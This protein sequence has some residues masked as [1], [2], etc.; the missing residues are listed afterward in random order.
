MTRSRAATA[1]L[2]TLLFAAPVYAAEPAATF[3]DT[4]KA[5]YIYKISITAEKGL[6][7][8]ENS[9]GDCKKTDASGNVVNASTPACIDKTAD[10]EWSCTRS[11]S[12]TTVCQHKAC[13]EGETIAQPD[14]EKLVHP[15][16][17]QLSG[18]VLSPTPSLPLPPSGQSIFAQ[19]TGNGATPSAQNNTPSAFDQYLF[20]QGLISKE[21]ALVP[22]TGA[23]LNSNTLFDTG[24]LPSPEA[25]ASSFT[26]TM[27]TPQ[28]AVTQAS[29]FAPTD[30]TVPAPQPR[31]WSSWASQTW[32]DLLSG[33]LFSGEANAAE[34]QPSAQPTVTVLNVTPNSGSVPA[35]TLS[36]TPESQQGGPLAPAVQGGGAAA[37]PQPARSFTPSAPQPQ[38][39]F[40]TGDTGNAA[41]QPPQ[42]SVSSAPF[43]DLDTKTP[44]QLKQ[45]EAQLS[46]QRSAD[47]ALNNPPPKQPSLAQGLLNWYVTGN[48]TQ[49]KNA[50]DAMLRSAPVQPVQ[51]A[52]LPPL[53]GTEPTQPVLASPSPE[54]ATP[55]TPETPAPAEPPSQPIE[56]VTP[57][58][59][60][61]P[62]NA[63]TGDE[64]QKVGD[65]FQERLA[66][67]KQDLETAQQA[68][69]VAKDLLGERSSGL[70]QDTAVAAAQQRLD[71]I[72][73][74]Y[75]EY[76]TYMNEGGTAPSWLQAAVSTARAGQGTASSELGDFVNSSQEAAGYAGKDFGKAFQSGSALDMLTSGGRWLG[77]SSASVLA[78][79]V[80]T[81]GEMFGVTGFNPNETSAYEQAIDPTGKATGAAF[82]FAMTG[83]PLLR[84]TGKVGGFAISQEMSGTTNF[85]RDFEAVWTPEAQA[86][87]PLAAPAESM[88]GDLGAAPATSLRLP[89][90][91]NIESSDIVVSEPLAPTAQTAISPANIVSEAGSALPKNAVADG[92]SLQGWA[93][94]AAV[95]GGILGF[96]F[97]PMDTQVIPQ[98]EEPVFVELAPVPQTLQEQGAEVPAAPSPVPAPTEVAQSEP[99]PAAAPA[100]QQSAPQQEVPAAPP[101][102]QAEPAVLPQE[103]APTPVLASPSPSPDAAPSEAAPAQTSQQQAAYEEAARVQA[104]IEARRQADAQAQADVQAAEEQKTADLYKQAQ[105]M[106]ARNQAVIDAQNQPLPQPVI[107]PPSDNPSEQGS[108]ASADDIAKGLAGTGAGTGN[109]G[110]RV[111]IPIQFVND[112]ALPTLQGNATISNLGEAASREAFK[113]Y[114]FVIE[115]YTDPRTPSAQWNYDNVQLSQARAE[116][117]R[118]T[119]ATMYDIPLQDI[120]AVGRGAANPILTPTGAIDYA[121]SRRVVVTAI[122]PR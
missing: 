19:V 91:A 38:S 58:P 6:A 111:S 2:L 101:A 105:E 65:V 26:R 107:A 56:P 71:G 64:L 9:D 116:A 120:T 11:S 60:G 97:A 31:T 21:P 70:V 53:A 29:T 45:I 77:W 4:C 36:P 121:A 20:S 84:V 113:G 75:S 13:K 49:A 106:A 72:Q 82:D 89:P 109:A 57:A 52:D 25:P 33:K 5:G 30:G 78:G 8:Q 66:A 68:A 119:I 115:G 96:A 35:Q 86:T 73:A 43:A 48:N 112:S 122:P 94:G 55:A 61:Q 14:L 117:V 110:N 17:P 41:T 98:A 74:K 1:L 15:V 62:S 83:G 69:L 10:I 27:E 79:S 34:P 50:W 108:A 67:A 40:S 59:E 32:S 118:Q 54:Q 22:N 3:K 81:G 24:N 103:A 39:A 37:E 18:G 87:Q 46:A 28:D 93:G 102:R 47:A 104:Q 51:T 7:V 100:P 114:T 85:V 63:P 76:A 12:G 95:T 80:Q 99:A 42:T 23:T 92:T 88:M 44:E 16:S 90:V